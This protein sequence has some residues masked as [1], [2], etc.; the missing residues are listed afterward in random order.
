[1]K[2]GLT[3]TNIL[4]ADSKGVI[5]EGRGNLD[6][7]KQRYAATTDARTLADAIVGADVFLGCSARAC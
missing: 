1:V 2:L 3:K 7:S 5:Y 4:V 6:P